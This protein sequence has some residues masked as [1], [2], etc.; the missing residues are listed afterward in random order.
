V[1]IGAIGVVLPVVMW[2]TTAWS[3]RYVSG[4]AVFLAGLMVWLTAF[5][6]LGMTIALLTQ[7]A[8]VGGALAIGAG[9]G[10]LLAAPVWIFA[11][12]GQAPPS[13]EDTPA[14]VPLAPGE[15]AAWSA[16][17]YSPALLNWT[18]GGVVVLAIAAAVTMIVLTR[19]LA[20]AIVLLPV[21]LVT[22]FALS[23]A[24]RVSVG[25]AGLTVRGLLGVPVWR[26]PA[27]DIVAADAVT[28]EPLGEF[29]GWGI[30]WAPGSS[31]KWRTGIVLRR[32]PALEVTRRDGRRLLVTVVDPATAA[33]VLRAYLR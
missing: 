2:A 25:P 15:V 10:L 14:A 21:A 22:L 5:L 31:G 3:A 28:V 27:S 20:W 23:A 17:S 29:G 19:G 9:A 18:I 12:R 33:A 8:N 11:P 4:V 7:P 32:G 30:R 16:T 24:W 1:L 6:G 13:E 26:V